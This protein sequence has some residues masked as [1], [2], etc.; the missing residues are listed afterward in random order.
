MAHLSRI[1]SISRLGNMALIYTRE[2][3]ARSSAARATSSCASVAPIHNMAACLPPVDSTG[4]DCVPVDSWG[5]PP[6]VCDVIEPA[7]DRPLRPEIAIGCAPW[8][9]GAKRGIAWG[10]VV[11]MAWCCCACDC[12][13]VRCMT[14]CTR[15]VEPRCSSW[16]SWETK[17]WM[18]SA[19]SSFSTC[20]LNSATKCVTTVSC[21]SRNIRM[22]VSVN[23]WTM[24]SLA[25]NSTINIILRIN[26]TQYSLIIIIITTCIN[27]SL[28]EY[29]QYIIMKIMYIPISFENYFGNRQ[30]E[31]LNFF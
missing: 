20:W 29:A 16:K 22:H 6:T 12:K 24:R 26:H 30:P 11:A 28:Y 21:C 13:C 15:R 18:H 7:V 5:A 31:I 27:P 1:S 2:K 17:P 10:E 4:G 8:R 25:L 14:C 19:F 23:S 3:R 9:S